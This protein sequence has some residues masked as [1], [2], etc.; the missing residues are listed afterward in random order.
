[1]SDSLLPCPSPTPRTCS[2]SS[3]ESVVPSNHLTLCHPLLLLFNPSLILS[4][5][6]LRVSH[7]LKNGLCIL[8]M[9]C[10]NVVQHIRTVVIHLIM[11]QWTL[12][13]SCQWSHPNHWF[14]L[15]SP[16]AAYQAIVTVTG[17]HLWPDR[18]HHHGA[19]GSIADHTVVTKNWFCCLHF[20]KS[21]WL[22]EC[23]YFRGFHRLDLGHGFLLS[24]YPGEGHFI[25]QWAS[26]SP[27]AFKQWPGAIFR[28]EC[29]AFL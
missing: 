4:Y 8:H 6:S 25:K 26:L 2:N 10:T 12:E 5:F 11:W 1:M 7:I 17:A 19:H 18:T 14:L 23:F 21:V 27:E 20:L 28:G 9:F 16:R 22:H 3:I 24:F 13:G 15:L 29:H